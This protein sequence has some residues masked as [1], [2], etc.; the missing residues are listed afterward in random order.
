MR[1]SKTLRHKGGGLQHGGVGALHGGVVVPDV[2]VGVLTQYFLWR[3]KGQL[4]KVNGKL[5][6]HGTQTILDHVRLN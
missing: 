5:E 4:Q 1:G 3:G 6:G 2:A